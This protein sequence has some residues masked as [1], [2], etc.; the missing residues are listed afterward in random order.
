MSAGDVFSHPVT[1]GIFLVGAVC[2]I[3]GKRSIVEGLFHALLAPACLAAVWIIALIGWLGIWFLVDLVF[4]GTDHGVAAMT[5]NWPEGLLFCLHPA[6]L[7]T[8]T[9]YFLYIRSE[10]GFDPQKRH[11]GYTARRGAS[12]PTNVFRKT[13]RW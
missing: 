13:V 1:W 10:R 4:P 11:S 9:I 7:V 6:T 5:R 2:G 8:A 12:N 3:Y